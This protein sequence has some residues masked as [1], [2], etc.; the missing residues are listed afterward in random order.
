[1]E[2]P[3][4]SKDWCGV[5]QCKSD[6]WKRGKYTYMSDVEFCTFPGQKRDSKS[7]KKWLS[8][9]MR[10]LDYEPQRSHRVCSLHFI[11]GKPTKENPFPTLFPRNNY[12][13]PVT[14]RSKTVICKRELTSTFDAMPVVCIQINPL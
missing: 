1:M 8:Q 5:H 14:E 10:P 9:I 12:G 7:R 3:K 11:D 4:L 2:R 13:R 6:G